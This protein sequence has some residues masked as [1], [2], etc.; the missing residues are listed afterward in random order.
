MGLF[1]LFAP[2]KKS[3]STYFLMQDYSQVSPRS[4]SVSRFNQALSKLNINQ[5]SIRSKLKAKNI[6][7]YLFVI[8]VT[9]AVLLGLR[10]ALSRALSPTAGKNTAGAV[11]VSTP[12]N[13]EFSF[14]VYDKNKQL[15]NPVRYNITDAQLTNTII[16][17]GQR[18]TAVKGRQFLIFNL[19]LVNDFNESLFLNTRNYVR[20]QPTGSADRLAPEIHNDTVEVQPL[21][22]KITRIGLPVNEGIKEFTVFVGELEGFKEEIYIKF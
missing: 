15:V 14:I 13:R 17:K 11:V 10:A 7:T 16:I 6:G 8:I 1:F 21:S 20:V 4:S 22:T 2:G 5:A 9:A 19:K 18:A 3:A 12:V